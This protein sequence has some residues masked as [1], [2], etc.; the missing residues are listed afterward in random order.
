MNTFTDGTAL[1]LVGSIGN[2]FNLNDMEDEF[3]I[4]PSPKASED[5]ESYHSRVVDGWIYV[6]PSTNSV[7]DMTSVIL[8][9]LAVESAN[10]VYDSLL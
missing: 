2:T 10:Y 9:A 8:E 6:V 1:F 4:L 5:Q 3:R 7:L